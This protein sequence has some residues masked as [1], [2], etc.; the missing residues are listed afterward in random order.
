MWVDQTE[1]TMEVMFGKKREVDGQAII[2]VDECSQS[3]AC[4]SEG[5]EERHG[6]ELVEDAE[7]NLRWKLMKM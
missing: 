5:E 6:I 3:A 1:K 2:V 7:E 4:L